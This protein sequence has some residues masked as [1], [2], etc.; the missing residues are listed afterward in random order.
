MSRFFAFWPKL[1]NSG[2][3]YAGQ[4]RV[5]HQHFGHS[6]DLG[7]GS[8]AVHRGEGCHSDVPGERRPMTPREPA[9]FSLF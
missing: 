2:G 5:L 1:E 9:A 3:Q 6:T 4:L 8:Y 7:L